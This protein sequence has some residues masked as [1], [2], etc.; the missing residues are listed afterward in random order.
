MSTNINSFEIYLIQKITRAESLVKALTREHT[1]IC[2]TT[3]A[4]AMSVK[5]NC[6]VDEHNTRINMI[7]NELKID[8][9]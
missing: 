4:T 7:L 3:D 2:P 8:L 9:K 6:G 5:C 1:A